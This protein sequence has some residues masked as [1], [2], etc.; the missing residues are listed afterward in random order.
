MPV[1]PDG[2]SSENKCHRKTVVDPSDSETS[3][4]GHPPGRPCN[5]LVRRLIDLVD[6]RAFFAVNF[7]IDEQSR[8]SRM[9]FRLVVF[10]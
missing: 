7:D 5:Q 3:V 8:S 1:I 2:L 6:V 10:E 9:P 4:S